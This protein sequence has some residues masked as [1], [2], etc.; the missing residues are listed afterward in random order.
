LR[1]DALFLPLA[2]AAFF[3]C[4]TRFGL[5]T[6]VVCLAAGLSAHRLVLLASCLATA[7]RISKPCPS[8]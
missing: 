3:V 7:R 2:L 5:E 1:I 4:S 8:A 6:A